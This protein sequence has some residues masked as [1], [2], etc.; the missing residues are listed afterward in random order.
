MEMSLKMYNFASA[1]FTWRKAMT[2]PTETK[3]IFLN[4]PLSDWDL[5]NELIRRFGWQAESREQLLESFVQS[6]PAIPALT[7]DEIMEEVK[8]VRYKQ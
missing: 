6:R 4:V 7:E 8:A 2:K 5:L 1:R 3:G